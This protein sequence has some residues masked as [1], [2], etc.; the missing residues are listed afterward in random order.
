MIEPREVFRTALGVHV[1]RQRRV[2]ARRR[3]R[4]R[5]FARRLG[6]PSRTARLLFRI[7]DVRTSSGFYQEARFWGPP[8][9]PSRGAPPLLRP[10]HRTCPQSARTRRIRNF[11]VIREPAS[12][13]STSPT[14][15]LFCAPMAYTL[16]NAR[17]AR[18]VTAQLP[19]G[20]GRGAG[21]RWS[22]PFKRRVTYLRLSITDRCDLRCT[23]CMPERMK[24][25]PKKDVLSFEELDQLVTVFASF[26]VDKLR[27]TGGEPLVRKDFMEL[28]ARFSRHS[29]RPQRTDAHHQRHAA[30][31]I[32]GRPGRHRRPPHQRF[33]RY[34]QAG[35]VRKD[36]PPRQLGDVMKGVD[37]A[38]AAGL[39]VKINTVALPT[40]TSTKSLI[41]SASPT[42]A[43]R[44]SR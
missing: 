29:A 8:V 43:A 16:I 36:L 2:E 33:A 20:P 9:L 40:S 39:K 4:P 23:Y 11:E 6:K 41:S 42:T 44:T 12:D 7:N 17:P 21:R 24:F 38:M 22:I 26:G 3:L 30:L 1:D 14:I 37:A 31:E 19:N 13:R 35:P 25:L 18:P 32:R 5:G 34:P 10:L 28:M 27:I 15:A